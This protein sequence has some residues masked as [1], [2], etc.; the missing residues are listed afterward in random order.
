MSSHRGAVASQNR[1]CP[2]V[3]AAVPFNTD[4]VRVTGV[5]AATDV[6][7]FPPAVTASDVAVGCSGA[8][9]VTTRGT[10]PLSAPEV[11]VTVAVAVPKLAELLAVS[12]NTLL[13]LVGFALQEPLTP[14]GNPLTARLT[15]PTNP[16]CGIT[17]TVDSPV[18]P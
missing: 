10:V 13:P 3:T 8:F 17:A 7:A 2:L 11:P 18:A 6:T 5:P 16:Y 15:L 9:T 14:L 4:A 1:T 12:V